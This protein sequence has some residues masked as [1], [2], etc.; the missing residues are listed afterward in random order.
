MVTPRSA[1]F[2]FGALLLAG[3]FDSRA[4]GA[5]VLDLGTRRELFVD[6]CFIG[7]LRGTTLKLHAPQ[8]APPVT[9]P[10]PNGHYATMLRDGDT[11]R[12]YYRGDKV[13]GTRWQD[14]WDRYQ[15]GQVTLAAESRDA[16]HWTLP[17]YGLYSHPTFP[18]GN[19]VLADEFLV[20]HNFTPFIDLKPGVPASERFKALG[21]GRYQ[22]QFE[23]F[24]A[25]YGPGGLKAYASAD[26]IRWRRM[27][28]KAVIPED[29]G[30]FDSQNHA[31]WSEAE[32]T[33]VCYFRIFDG[34][35]RSIARTTSDDFIHWTMPVAMKPNAPREELYTAGTQPYFRAPHLYVALPT[36]F[37]DKRGAATDI[38]FMTSRGGDRFDRT[39]LE[40]FIR[41]GLGQSG[42]ANRANYAALGIHQTGPTEMSLFLTG[43]RRY[44]LR[45]DGFASINAPFSGGEMVT[46]PMRF[47]GGELEL[48]F[49]TSAGGQVL[50]EIQDIDGA[51]LPGFALTDCVPIFGDEIARVA[52]WKNTPDLAAVANRPVRLRFA[53]EDADLFSFRFR[54]MSA[55][56]T[57]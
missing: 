52:K 44:T 47:E 11:F 56:G 39:F 1:L 57:P 8:L 6:R 16:I 50:V 5:E 12:F 38:A 7:E 29:W 24:R 20:N 46:K 25:K 34:G 51:P 13:P 17:N 15:A 55:A 19:I 31:F 22:K 48:N 4:G 30:S 43:G 53:M 54:P 9:P 37:V 21:G 2:V 23:Q 35:R 36:R 32:R 41:P 18:Q 33:Y 10:R 27:Q 42:W 49:S 45:L 40:S 26:G 3:T 14:G 28:E